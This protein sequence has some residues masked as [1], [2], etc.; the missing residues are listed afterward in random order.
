MSN[1]TLAL[2]ELELAELHRQQQRT[3]DAITECRYQDV[4]WQAIADVF[5]HGNR[6]AAKRWYERRTRNKK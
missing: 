3:V 2:F 1:E 5:G 4:T 6:A